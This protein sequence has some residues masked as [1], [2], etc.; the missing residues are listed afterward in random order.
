MVGQFSLGAGFFAD[1]MVV[2]G[3]ST[4]T[5][6]MG[7][8]SLQAVNIGLIKLKPGADP[9][10][11]ANDL[12]CFFG[13]DVHA[14]TRAGIEA[15]EKNFWVNETSVGIVFRCGVV[16][17]VLVGIVFVYQVISSDIGSRL[18][19]F[20]TLKA[21]GYSDLYL[22]FTVIHQAILLAVFGFVPGMV[23]SFILYAVA[24]LGAGIPIGIPGEP[25]LVVLFRCLTV[26]AT[27]V[28]LCC[29]SG[30]FALGKLKSADP[31]DLF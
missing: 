28:G 25:T 16:V 21:M 15:R 7:A 29:L 1:G 11:V 18:K 6:L 14:W 13:P 26:L 2:V 10:S 9:Q 5:R 3:D 31:A 24:Y 27:T 20:A 30:L 17:A 12:N 8:G 22:A 4:F 23:V 19:E